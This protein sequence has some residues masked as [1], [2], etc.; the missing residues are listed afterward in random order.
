MENIED[1]TKENIT[2]MHNT[3]LSFILI[4]L[5]KQDENKIKVSFTIEEMEKISMEVL[6]QKYTLNT[7]FEP[8]L[9]EDGEVTG[10]ELIL[11][12]FNK[13]E[14]LLQGLFGGDSEI[15]M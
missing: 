3:I 14:L 5:D 7:L 2:E 12:R 10:V 1:F 11:E 6:E 13:S 4:L 15:L 9:D 8:I